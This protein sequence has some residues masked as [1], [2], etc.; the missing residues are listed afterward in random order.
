VFIFRPRVSLFLGMALI[1]FSSCTPGSSLYGNTP[2]AAGAL[3]PVSKGSDSTYQVRKGLLFVAMP[4]PDTPYNDVQIYDARKR[5]PKPIAYIR[6]GVD[7]PETLCID[8]EKRILYVVNATGFISEYHLGSTSPFATIT[9]GID[10]PAFCAID[11]S[12]N[13]WVSNVGGQNVT[14]YLYGSSV[15][16]KVVSDG[17]PYPVGLAF[18]GAGT[19][20]V[21]NRTRSNPNIQVFSQG[22]S[23][24]SRTITNGVQWPVGIGV[25]TAG[26]LYVTNLIPGN[27]AEYHSGSSKPYHTIVQD[28][29]GP[30]AVA[31]SSSGWMYVS[32]EGVQGGGT[33][34][35]S[36]VLEFPPH[37]QVP[38]KKMVTNGLYAQQGIAFYPPQH[39]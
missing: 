3:G 27:I 21:A 18:D 19:L 4:D 34:P 7:Q 14:E 12:S 17:L 10:E 31:F 25:D 36:A 23:S 11:K 20:Y 30:F 28:M 16:D 22:G 13:L 37:S 33:G 39:Y 2:R 24:P 32:N 35:S 5:N 8:G 15:P 1:A 26:T 9:Q 6:S 38:I 29:N